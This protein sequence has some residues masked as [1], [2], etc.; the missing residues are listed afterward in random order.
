MES[1]LLHLKNLGT[2]S[3]NWLHAVGIHTRDELERIGPVEAYQRV[4]ARGI[5][6]SK[7]LLYALQGALLGVHWTE[8]DPDLKQL[9]RQQ[10][11]LG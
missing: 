7:V 3:V 2:T 9:L 1:D 10:A 4:R 11:E 5:R 8:L 6:A